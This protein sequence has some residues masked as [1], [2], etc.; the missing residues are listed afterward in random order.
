[1]IKGM[2]HRK[3]AVMCV[4]L[5]TVQPGLAWS[6]RGHRLVNLVAAESLPKDM[7]TFMRSPAAISQ[8]SYLGPEPDRWRPEVEPE[9]SNVAGPDHVFR[10]E[11]GA[12][13]SPLP[14]RRTEF[15]SR[16]EELRAHG[17]ADTASLRSEKIG[18]LPWQAE[19][20]YERLQSAFR[21][22]RIATGEMKESEWMDEAP[23]RAEV[24]FR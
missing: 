16:L 21:S 15:L 13:V 23:I 14:R 2:T 17:G 12:L 20:V 24:V 9:L 7:P 8:I 11:L 10:I 18:T 3:I 19:E 5:L 6:N 22:Y 4:A 1:M